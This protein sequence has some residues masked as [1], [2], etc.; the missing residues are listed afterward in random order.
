MKQL[1]WIGLQ[2]QGMPNSAQI[3][4]FLEVHATFVNI[5]IVMYLHLVFG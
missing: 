3:I 1:V 4:G 2:M 5:K